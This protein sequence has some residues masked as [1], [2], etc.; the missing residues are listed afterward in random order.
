MINPGGMLDPREIVGRDREIARYWS[1][2]E[3]QGL[4]LGGERRIG[5]THILRKMHE[6]GH[7]GFVT[8]FQE[9][10]GIESLSELV[11]ELYHAMSTLLRRGKLKAAALDLWESLV[12]QQIKSFDLPHVKDN[13]KAL[14]KQAITDALEVVPPEDKLVLIWDE[15]PLMAHNIKEREGAQSTIQLLD[16]LRHIRQTQPGAS[17]LRFLMTGSIGLHHVL[18]SLHAHGNANAPVNDMQSE[19][20]P[21]MSAEDA[22]LLSTRLLGEIDP[23]A[24]RAAR[25]VPLAQEMFRVVEGFPFYLQHVADRLSQLERPPVVNDVDE[26]V[27]TLVLAPEDPGNFNYNVERIKTYYDERDAEIALAVLGAIAAKDRAMGLASLHKIVSVEVEG[28][29]TE[30]I[31]AVCALL[32]QDH[33]LQRVPGKKGATYDFRWSLVKRWWQRHQL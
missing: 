4:L 28:V 7:P 16:V 13:W 29:T 3:R 5:K 17:R 11:R 27:E 20:V 21:P 23:E 8:V 32:V 15:F 1:V 12:P 14:L 10:E 6:E 30:Q 31:R 18:K 24:T 26:A 33:C 22:F 9:L 25:F 19:T 2:L